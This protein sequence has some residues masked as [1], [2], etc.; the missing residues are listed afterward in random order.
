MFRKSFAALAASLMTFAAF[1][2][3]L[4]ALSGSNAIRTEAVPA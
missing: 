1:T 4:A 2:A 3:T